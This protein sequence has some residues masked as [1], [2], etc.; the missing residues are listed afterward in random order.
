[1]NNVTLRV[2]DWGQSIMKH[3]VAFLASIFAVTLSLQARA[4]VDTISGTM[5]LP[6]CAA[7]LDIAHGK[8]PA[9]DSPEA[10][11]QLRHATQCVAAVNAVVKLAPYLKPEFAMC[12]SGPVP[13]PQVIETVVAYFKAHPDQLPQNFHAVAA[14]A[15]AEKWPCK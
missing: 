6:S 8:R 10:A 1:M 14:R 13:T 2:Q 3:I 12:P 4:Q 7:A 15:L 5:V 11:S 9:A